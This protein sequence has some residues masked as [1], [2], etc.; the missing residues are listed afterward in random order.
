MFAHPDT[1]SG[2]DVTHG[3]EWMRDDIVELATYDWIGRTAL[4]L[5][6]L[7]PVVSL[8]LVLRGSRPAWIPLGITIALATMWFFY[9][10]TDWWGSV[11]GPVGSAVLLLATGAGWFIAAWQLVK[12]RRSAHA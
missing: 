9:N 12:G 4:I 2:L 6:L 8:I 1:I 7:L 10:A 5:F 11:G 3:I